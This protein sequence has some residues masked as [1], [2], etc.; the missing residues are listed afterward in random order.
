MD[1]IELMQALIEKG[2]EYDQDGDFVN[3][4]AID[5][6]NPHSA[7]QLSPRPFPLAEMRRV[8]LGLFISHS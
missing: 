7:P 3:V 8:A 6:Y 4:E 2:K 1:F 5:C